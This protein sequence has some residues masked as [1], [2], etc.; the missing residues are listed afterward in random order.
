VPRQDAQAPRVVLDLQ[1]SL[2]TGPLEAELEAADATEERD[3]FHGV[4][5]SFRTA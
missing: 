4:G 2:D 1:H 5:N 3:R